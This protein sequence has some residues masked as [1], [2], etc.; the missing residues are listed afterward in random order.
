LGKVHTKTLNHLQEVMNNYDFDIIYKK[1]SEMRAN[2]SS[3]NLI[4]SVWLGALQLQQA[5]SVDPLL[6]AL[7]LFVV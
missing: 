2:Y 5:Q 1:G 3:R 4:N 6:Q 7:K